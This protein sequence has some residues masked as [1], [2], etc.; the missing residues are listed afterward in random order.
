MNTILGD[1]I[2]NCCSYCGSGDHGYEACDQIQAARVDGRPDLTDTAAPIVEPVSDHQ[3]DPFIQKA[4]EVGHTSCHRSGNFQCS[5]CGTLRLDIHESCDDEAV[6]RCSTCGRSMGIWRKVKRDF[7]ASAG[8]GVFSLEHGQ[9]LRLDEFEV[10][11]DNRSVPP[12]GTGCAR[13]QY[14]STPEK[15]E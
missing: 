9:F 5:V 6:I 13:P 3:I 14:P 7:S 15:P 2:G 12:I 1:R 8:A 10:I 4:F 11:G